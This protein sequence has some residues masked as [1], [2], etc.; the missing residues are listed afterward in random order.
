MYDI[1]IKYHTEK[2]ASKEK[3]TVND[4]LQIIFLKFYSFGFLICSCIHNNIHG[5]FDVDNMSINFLP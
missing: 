1:C 2:L 4:C 3:T 5:K